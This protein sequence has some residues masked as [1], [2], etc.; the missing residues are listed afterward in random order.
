MSFTEIDIDR[1]P[2][3]VPELLKLI[4]HRRIVPVLVEGARICVAPDGGSEF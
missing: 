3:L 2:E 1:N 4:G